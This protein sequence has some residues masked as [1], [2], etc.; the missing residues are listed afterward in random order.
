MPTLELLLANTAPGSAEPSLVECHL[1]SLRALG[2]RLSALKVQHRC[3]HFACTMRMANSAG[4]VGQM[5]MFAP[6]HQCILVEPLT[7]RAIVC[8]DWS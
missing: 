7:V 2:T 4:R 8:H 3:L 6:P 1:S 5:I